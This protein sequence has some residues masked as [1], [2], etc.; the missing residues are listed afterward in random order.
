MKEMLWLD[1]MQIAEGCIRERYSA[2]TH[3]TGSVQSHADAVPRLQC[4]DA[5]PQICIGPLHD[6][7]ALWLQHRAYPEQTSWYACFYYTGCCQGQ[8]SNWSE[9][10]WL[11]RPRSPPVQIS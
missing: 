1:M 10:N 5:G 2:P 8:E 7:R 3:A 11:F 9:S 6:R 4:H